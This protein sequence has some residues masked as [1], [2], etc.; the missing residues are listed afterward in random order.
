MTVL[1]SEGNNKP[2]WRVMVCRS[3]C[4]TTLEA[5]CP[6]APWAV[7]GLVYVSHDGNVTALLTQGAQSL[8]GMAVLG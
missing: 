6:S 5:Q 3:R 1:A 2:A 8:H 4:I 7:W